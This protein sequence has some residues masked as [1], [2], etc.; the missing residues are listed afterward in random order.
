MD[1]VGEAPVAGFG[2]RDPRVGGVTFGGSAGCGCPFPA[3]AVPPVEAGG[4]GGP[5]RGHGGS[6]GVEGVG[7]G[8][9]MGVV[10]RSECLFDSG[11]FFVGPLQTPPEERRRC[12]GFGSGQARAG[13]TFDALADLS[14]QVPAQLN[15]D[16]G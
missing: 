16:V 6:G 4:G 1:L 11:Q 14:S 7:G 8:V 5:R 2:D 10:E 9:E 3:A 13:V 12:G 15:G